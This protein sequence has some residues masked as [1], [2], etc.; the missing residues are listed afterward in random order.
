MIWRVLAGFVWLWRA[1]E[2]YHADAYRRAA[3]RDLDSLE[4]MIDIPRSAGAKRWAGHRPERAVDC[5]CFRAWQFRSCACSECRIGCREA[6][7]FL[8]R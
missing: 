4:A 7:R 3:L 2:G 8:N 5:S 6:R 1:L